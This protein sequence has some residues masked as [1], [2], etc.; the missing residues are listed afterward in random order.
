MVLSDHLDM[1]DVELRATHT[2]TRKANGDILQTKIKNVI[3]PW[4]A[5]KFMPLTQRPWS[6]NSY[7]TSKLWFKCCSVDL[8]VSDLSFISSQVK[9]WL[10]A[11]MLEKPEEMVAHRPISA[12]GLGLHS[13]KYRAQAMLIKTFLETAVNPKFFKSLFHSTLFRYHVLGE[14]DLPDPGYPPYYSKEFFLTIK[15][16]H[17]NTPLNVSTLSSKQW[18]QLLVEDNL[19]M[20]QAEA[21]APRNYL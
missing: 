18:Y 12:G 19:T 3:G 5:G 15:S 21:D 16:V 7:A 1:V 10:Y 6:L 2:Q 9:S 11:D 14:T 13:V 17:E 4:R 8:R 20:G